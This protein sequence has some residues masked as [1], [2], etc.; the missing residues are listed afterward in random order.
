MQKMSLGRAKQYLYEY[1]TEKDDI[2]N[3]ILLYNN[4][5]YSGTFDLEVKIMH[6]RHWNT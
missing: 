5:W 4:A 3:C 2:N 6:V 1:R